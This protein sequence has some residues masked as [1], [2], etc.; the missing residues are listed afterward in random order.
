MTDKKPISQLPGVGPKRAALYKKLDLL[1]VKD[2]LYHFP[3]DYLDFNDMVEIEDIPVGETGIFRAVVKQKL[4]PYISFRHTIYR[5]VL[6]NGKTDILCTFFNTSY[7]FEK[8][9]VGQTYLFYGRITGDF[10][11]REISSPFFISAEEE[12]KLI[13]KYRLTS[14]LTFAMIRTNLRTALS[15]YNQPDPL[16]DWILNSYTLLGLKDALTKIHFP[17]NKEEYQAARRRLA[18][19]ELLV[20]RLGLEKLKAKNCKKTSIPL[21]KTDLNPFLRVLPFTPTS[22][23]IKAIAE[24]M[25]DMSKHIPMNRLLQGDVGSGKTL[26]AAALCYHTVLNG[27]QCAFMAPTEMLAKQ[28]YKT[29]CDFLEPHGIQVAL[30]TGAVSPAEKKEIKAGLKSNSIQVVVGTHALLQKSVVFENLMLVITDEQHRFGVNQR[31][32]LEQK[33]KNP[34]ALVMSATPIPR[35]LALF[36]YADLDISVLDVMPKGRK[37]IRTYAVDS[38][39]RER[40]FAFI[41]KNAKEGRQAYIV[42]PMISENE[43][44]KAAAEQYFEE[45][46][47]IHL[48]DVSIGLLHGKLKQT[49]KDEIMERFRNNEISV[50]VSTT[51][52][53]VG[54]DVPNATVMLIENA[55]QFGLSQLHQ[56]RGRIGRGAE[57]SHCI[58]LTDHQS[59]YTKARM[60]TM[61]STSDGF[62]IADKDLELRGP[63]DFFGARQHGLPQL[64]IA[65]ISADWELLKETGELSAQLLK[66]KALP[67]LLED[68][69]AHLMEGSFS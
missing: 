40:L 19:Q 69:V 3:R 20:L 44:Q 63:G 12:N 2:L 41:R 58:L 9:Q 60:E 4:T 5:A 61:V 17:K 27:Y 65:D 43:N 21:K 66:E 45:L 64:K 47:S 8:L 30:L 53:E 18:F 54:I 42:C 33:G 28:H 35:T 36:I 10:L 48:T 34:H 25:E 23:Q 11:R 13:P 49:E 1:T 68:E 31:H 22:A 62:K 51:V 39:Y 14:S 29:L 52:I 59:E 37:P 15:L 50:L 46:K 6:T 55:E 16:P 57:Q 56:L 67:P 7:T 32:T 38:S 26:V 24:C